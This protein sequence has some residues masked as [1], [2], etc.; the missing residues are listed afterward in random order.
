[1]MFVSHIR[2]VSCGAVMQMLVLFFF[3][4]YLEQAETQFDFSE[5]EQ[6]LGCFPKLVTMANVHK[7]VKVVNVP[8]MKTDQLLVTLF[9]ENKPIL[10][11]LT[12]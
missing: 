2:K 1:M 7:L 10:F 11:D 5:R 4:L 8:G 12:A 9:S 6:R 3:W